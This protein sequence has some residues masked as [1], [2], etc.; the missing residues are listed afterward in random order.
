MAIDD[1][2][3]WNEPFKLDYVRMDLEGYKSRSKVEK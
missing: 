3:L 1:K 2:Q